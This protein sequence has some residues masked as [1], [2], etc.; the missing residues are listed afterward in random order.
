MAVSY[1][2]GSVMDTVA[3]LMN[4]SAKTLFTYTVQLPYLKMA[5]QELDQQLNLNECP[6]N[7]I[8]EYESTVTSGVLNLS[9]PTSFFL[10][11]WLK[12]RAT[13]STL[14][15]D[16]SLMTEVAD[17]NK[18]SLDQ[19]TTLVYW[20]FRHNCINFIGATAAREVRM[21]Y[22]RHSTAF[23]DDGSFV[24]QYGAANFLAYKTGALI[25]R[26]IRKQTDLADNLELQAA[27]ALDLILSVLVKNTQGV[28]VRRLPFRRSGMG[29]GV[30]IVR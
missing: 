4:D 29:Q 11:L 28:R 19:T 30:V 9:L 5:Q 25:A 8:S 10:P 17:V 18:L 27:Q 21:G 16:Y 13:T 24:L 12:E 23:V 2:A 14:E 15:S 3:A 7:E 20:D 26:F 22:W 6:L 1:T